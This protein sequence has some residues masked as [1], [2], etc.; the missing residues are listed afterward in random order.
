M[1]IGPAPLP[2]R[3]RHSNFAAI[4]SLRYG[5]SEPAIKNAARLPSRAQRWCPTV[6]SIISGD[7]GSISS[8]VMTQPNPGTSGTSRR[9]SIRERKLFNAYGRTA[10]RR[11]SA[12]TA[13]SIPEKDEAAR[14][15]SGWPQEMASRDGLSRWAAR[16]AHRFRYPRACRDEQRS[17]RQPDRAHSPYEREVRGGSSPRTARAGHER[18]DSGPSRPAEKRAAALSARLQFFLSSTLY[19]NICSIL[20]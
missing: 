5:G 19:T 4:N 9:P 13:A 20:C 10:N 17:P 8:I 16:R 15:F 18:D 11:N 14:S 7:V 3:S 6:N 1:F 12:T 2:R